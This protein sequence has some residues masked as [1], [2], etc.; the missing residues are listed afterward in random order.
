MKVVEF[1]IQSIPLLISL[2]A[3]KYQKDDLELT[4]NELENDS[5]VP[6]IQTYDFIVGKLTF[7]K[8]ITIV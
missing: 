7:L 8:H 2:Y 1:L 4:L 6:R 5:N 3:E